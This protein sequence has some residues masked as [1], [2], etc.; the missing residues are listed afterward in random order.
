MLIILKTNG[1]TKP[2]SMYAIEMNLRA[3]YGLENAKEM[4]YEKSVCAGP[5]IAMSPTMD[6]ISF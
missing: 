5:N 2:E 3:L 1:I 6:L 4:K